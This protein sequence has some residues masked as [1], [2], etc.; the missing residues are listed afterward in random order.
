MSCFEKRPFLVRY[1]IRPAGDP[2]C[3]CKSNSSVEQL[4]LI[5]WCPF[6]GTPSG[7]IVDDR[8]NCYTFYIAIRI[9]THLPNVKHC[10]TTQPRHVLHLQIS[11]R[12]MDTSNKCNRVAG[13]WPPPRLPLAFAFQ[14]I[15][16]RYAAH[17]MN[18]S[19]LDGSS[20][21]WTLFKLNCTARI[22]PTFW[23]HNVANIIS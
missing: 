2:C 3:L 23:L 17:R 22:I 21:R 5:L 16:L 19:M 18:L 11:H 10:K 7:F 4:L 6:S 12:W 1:H 9:Y 8:K 20:T 14:S 15:A 13:A